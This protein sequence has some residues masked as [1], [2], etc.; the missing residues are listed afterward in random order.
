MQDFELEDFGKVEPENKFSS[1]EKDIDKAKS[2]YKKSELKSDEQTTP[3]EVDL[4]EEDLEDSDDKKR[5]S[6]RPLISKDEILALLNQTE[7]ERLSYGFKEG[8]DNEKSI[9][10]VPTKE[11][12]FKDFLELPA[13][14]TKTQ[15]SISGKVLPVEKLKKSDETIT[16]ADRISIEGKSGST[17]VVIH[18]DY[19]KD[20]KAI[21]VRTTDGEKFLI[22][23]EESVTD[24]DKKTIYE[25]STSEFKPEPFDLHQRQN[26]KDNKETNIDFENFYKMNKKMDYRSE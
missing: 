21:E 13:I 22:T 16:I 4:G 17:T 2:V 9:E 8:I 26:D 3:L 14:A 24:S 1:E 20:I 11:Q 19:N 15:S 10:E 6:E 18:R 5:G 12:A 7:E 23:L 25:D